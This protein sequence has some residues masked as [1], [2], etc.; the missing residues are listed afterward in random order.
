MLSQKKEI[1]GAML[2]AGVRARSGNYHR[3]ACPRR[4]PQSSPE[5]VHALGRSAA[6]SSESSVSPSPRRVRPFSQNAATFSRDL[7]GREDSRPRETQAGPHEVQFAQVIE[8]AAPRERADHVVIERCSYVPT[9]LGQNK[10]QLDDAAFCRW[11][12]ASPFCEVFAA[13]SLFSST[14]V[15]PR[16]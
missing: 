11:F 3:R 1:V 12:S 15:P 8:E 10:I 6:S 14:P 7:S 16:A 9:R 13:P 4:R 5:H 2:R